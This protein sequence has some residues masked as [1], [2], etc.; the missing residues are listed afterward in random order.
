MRASTSAAL[1]RRLLT[2]HPV[3]THVIGA[4]RRPGGPTEDGV[5]PSKVLDAWRFDPT[6]AGD[7][8]G[9]G[10]WPLT[11]TGDL[12][13]ASS[14]VTDFRA[15]TA[16]EHRW[17]ESAEQRQW[18]GA[19]CLVAATKLQRAAGRTKATAEEAAAA[20]PG[21][22]I[23]PDPTTIWNRAVTIETGPDRI[24]PWLVQTGYGRAGSMLRSG[25]IAWCG[26]C[27]RR[28]AGCSFPSS[29]TSP[30]MTSWTTDP[31]TSASG[32][33]GSSI[34][35]GRWSIGLLGTRGA[36]P[37]WIRPTRTRSRDG[38][39]SSWRAAR[40]SSIGGVPPERDR[41]R[42]DPTADPD[43]GHQLAGLAATDALRAGRR[44][45][46]RCRAPPTSNRRVETGGGPGDRR[47][48]PTPGSPAAAT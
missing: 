31:A 39:A 33:C 6:S 32:G 7:T 5:H 23:I 2:V 1:T 10:L 46:E 37:R 20:R 42:P 4:A 38:R 27:P 26:G 44:V 3:R 24:W 12:T 34:P 9:S 35:N 30:S 14:G 25:S 18:W 43:P 48:S 47:A 22:D 36:V 40:T 16:R 11:T 19:V 8:A 41:A 21:D 29:R 45:P 15:A 13:A 28:T 17:A